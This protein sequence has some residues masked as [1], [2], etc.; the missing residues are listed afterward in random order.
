M[1]MSFIPRRLKV[2]QRQNQ[3]LICFISPIPQHSVCQIAGMKEAFAE[4]MK[5]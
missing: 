3:Y 4:Y 5:K 1:N 2:P